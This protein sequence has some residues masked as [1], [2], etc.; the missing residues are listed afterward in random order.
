MPT[1]QEGPI[2][3]FR[4]DDLD[5]HS[6]ERGWLA[7]FFRHDE[8]KGA[9]HPAMG[10]VSMSYPGV[11]RGPH[12]HSEQADLFVFAIGTFRLFLWD[13][14]ADSPTRG[15]RQRHTVGSERPVV[16]VI[17]PGIVHAYRNVGEEN[18]F[19]INC[20]N[21]LYAGENKEHPVDEIRHENRPDSPFELF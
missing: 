2:A 19:V 17:P 8:L 5:L 16:A 21:R 14:R 4:M 7:E 20:P 11:T 3:D 1:W 15:H 10:Y 12:E 18:A 9:L 13:D 6:D